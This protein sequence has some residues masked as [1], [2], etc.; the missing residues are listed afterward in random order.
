LRHPIFELF[1][2]NISES[3]LIVQFFDELDR[4]LSR[5]NRNKH[6]VA[7][8]LLTGVLKNLKDPTFVPDLL[9]KNYLQHTISTYKTAVGRL[10]DKEFQ[11]TTQKLFEALLNSLKQ[12][13][14]KHKIKIKVLKK[15]L[16]YPGTFIFEKV[17]KSKL[18]QNITG[19]LNAEGVKKL[20]GIYREVVLATSERV[21]N[22]SLSERWWNMDRVYASHLL[23]KLVNHPSMS[24]EGEWKTDQLIFLMKLGLL[25][26]QSDNV[27][28]E[29]ADSFKETFYSSL[30]L[31]HI[32]LDDLRSILSKVVQEL[33]ATVNEDNIGTVLRHPL[34]GD[35]Y[36]TWKRTVEL[37]AKLDADPKKK[38]AVFHTLFLHLGLQLFNNPK[39][40]TESLTELFSCYKRTKKPKSPEAESDDPLWI[41]VVV[42]LFLNLLSHSSHLLRSVINYVFPHL[43]KYMNATAIHQIL[44]VL[45][46]KNET[47]PLSKPD[48][49][50]DEEGEESSGEEQSSESEDE[51]EDED[52]NVSDKL[53][54]ALQQA[55]GADAAS[56]AESVDLDN[57]DDEE[58]DKLD[59]ALGQAFKQFRPN[60][61]RK[62]KQNK[63][64]ETLTHFRIRVLDLIEMYLNSNPSM[65]LTLEIMLPLLQTLEFCVRDDHQRPL[66]NR[67]KACLKK[68]SALKKF[69]DCEGVTE[70]VLVD[71]LKSLLDKGTKNAIIVQEMGE[72]M[73]ESCIFVVSC[74]QIVANQTGTPVKKKKK[75]SCV[76]D[77]IKESLEDFFKRRDCITPYVLFKNVLQLN[78]EGIVELVPLLTG[79]VFAS[80]VRPF[81]RTQG[82]ELLKMFYTNQRF[83]GSHADQTKSV[84]DI[85]VNFLRDCVDFFREFCANPSERKVKEKFICSLFELLNSVKNSVLGKGFDGWGLLAETVRDCRAQL[86]FSR[87]TKLAFNKLCKSLNVSNVVE[88]KQKTVKLN[89]VDDDDD[90][91]LTKKQDKKKKKKGRNKDNLKLK[92]ESKELRMQS[93]SEGFGKRKIDWEGVQEESKRVKWEA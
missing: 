28:Q 80:S 89:H 70:E 52:E 23:A 77:V 86:T 79:F 39:L 43:C 24:E 49:S 63:D 57:L 22:E 91:E 45:D 54:M 38:K 2:E 14:V 55:L 21:V 73:A 1:I 81:R 85:T 15:L 51:E 46:P 64:E 37:V 69:S 60:L 75:K 42:D 11:E 18:V 4:T 90:D 26:D 6:L 16:F 47:N 78:W 93:L 59:E 20:G 66:L 27:G 58:G 72:K 62:K 83:I 7:T 9:T 33:D 67:V 71:L 5:P 30:D 56:D 17:T 12:D 35:N 50:E 41:E 84:E 65:L 13:G 29:L 31:K 74:S 10:K 19:T 82:I 8:K 88:L 68:L 40:A 92:K 3:D 25:R 34:T 36:D 61:G 87:D 44:S 32:K 53:R 48:E 76:N